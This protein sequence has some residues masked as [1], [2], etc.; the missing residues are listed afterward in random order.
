[1]LGDIYRN[2]TLLGQEG[3]TSPGMPLQIC[4]CQLFLYFALFFQSYKITEIMWLGEL[5]VEIEAKVEEE[6]DSL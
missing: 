3:A 1:M 4:L 2:M 5:W 6:P